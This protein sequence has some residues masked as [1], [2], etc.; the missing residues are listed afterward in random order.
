MTASDDLWRT[1]EEAQDDAWRAAVVYARAVDGEKGFEYP[2]A[3][4]LNVVEAGRSVLAARAAWQAAYKASRES[5][6]SLA[7]ERARMS[8]ENDDANDQ[9]VGLPGWSS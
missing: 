6:D 5:V 2:E 1:Y 4:R 8:D 9:A 7:D 3:F